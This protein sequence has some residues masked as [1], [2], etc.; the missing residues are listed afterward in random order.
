MKHGDFENTESREHLFFE[1]ISTN[2]GFCVCVPGLSVSP[3]DL[4]SRH[5]SIPGRRESNVRVRSP[6]TALHGDE[7]AQA[8]L[9]NDMTHLEYMTFEEM[10]ERSLAVNPELDP[11]KPEVRGYCDGARTHNPTSAR[12]RLAPSGAGPPGFLTVWVCGLRFFERHEATD[13]T[14][15]RRCQRNELCPH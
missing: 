12:L 11:T 13:E 2:A 10:Y 5:V 15:Q 4:C 6:T 9:P 8:T 1:A 3:G 7:S 14:M